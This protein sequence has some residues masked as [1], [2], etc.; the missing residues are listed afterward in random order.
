MNAAA[1][2]LMALSAGGWSLMI[3][4]VGFVIGL[5]GFCFYKVLASPGTSGHMQDP[6]EIDTHDRDT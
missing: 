1:P 4:S 3:L 6:M 2:V 5:A